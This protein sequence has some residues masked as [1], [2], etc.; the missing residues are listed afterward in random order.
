MTDKPTASPSPG[1]AGEPPWP[2]PDAARF[3]RV[4]QRHLTRLI[5]ADR[6]KSIT[7]GRRRLIPAAEVRRIADQ[8]C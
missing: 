5:T 6:V 2:I 7:I 4:S 3:L 1:G 8:G